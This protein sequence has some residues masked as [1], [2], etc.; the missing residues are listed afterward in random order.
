MKQ[1]ERWSRFLCERCQK[2]LFEKQ[3]IIGNNGRSRMG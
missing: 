1:K 3:V 2:R